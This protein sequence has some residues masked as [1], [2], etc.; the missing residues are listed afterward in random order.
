MERSGSTKGF[1]VDAATWRVTMKECRKKP[2]GSKLR[3]QFVFL[4]M[5]T[6]MVT[7]EKK[8]RSLSSREV[9]TIPAV[10]SERPV[11]RHIIHRAYR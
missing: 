1:K 9:H 4:R 5:E 10:M 3:H 6:Y 11:Y 7:P 2:S 8:Y